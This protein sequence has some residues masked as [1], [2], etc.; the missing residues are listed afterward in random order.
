MAHESS[1]DGDLWVY[2]ERTPQG[3]LA[4]VSLELLGRGRELA[5]ELDCGVAGVLLGCDK[6]EPLTKQAIAGGADTVFVATHELL[7]EYSTDAWTMVLDNLLG[8]HRPAILLIGATFNGRDLAGRLAVRTHTGLTAD[9]VRLEID[10]KTKLLLSGVPGFGGSIIAMI[11]CPEHRPQ[12]ATVRPGIFSARD[13]EPRRKG[14]IVPVQVELLPDKIHTTLRQRELQE[15]I[16]ITTADRVVATG[17][18]VAGRFAQWQELAEQLGAAV[19]A[20][21]PLADEG[22]VDRAQQIGSTGVSIKPELLICA[23]ISGAAHF[24]AGIADAGTVVAINTDPDAPIFEH[25]D[26]C[27]VGDADEILPP[28]LAA[29]TEDA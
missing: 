8:E 18:G 14:D 7:A 15:T 11:L 1:C 17:V 13:P 10:P 16:D 27:L 24:T 12:M 20:T 26:Y 5:A 23:G 19:G 21:R 3:T 29:L 25:A 4:P 6:L 9:V 2:L 28:L 22:I